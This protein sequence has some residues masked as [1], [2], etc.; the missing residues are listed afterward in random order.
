VLPYRIIPYYQPVSHISTYV[1]Y[2]TVHPKTLSNGEE[3]S[4][5]YYHLLLDSEEKE[6]FSWRLS[7]SNTSSIW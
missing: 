6:K 2:D 1:Q 4:P 3:A 5:N 7:S